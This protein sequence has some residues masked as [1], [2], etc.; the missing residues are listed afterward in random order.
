MEPLQR[1]FL[2]EK[3]F[4]SQFINRYLD[5]LHRYLDIFYHYGDILQH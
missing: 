5:I 2:S 4:L 1:H 3:K